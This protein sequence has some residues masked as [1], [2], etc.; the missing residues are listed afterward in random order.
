MELG[1]SSGEKKGAPISG[2]SQDLSHE[3]ATSWSAR[4]APDR[5]QTRKHRSSLGL[6][7]LKDA[8]HVCRS[9]WLASSSYDIL[10]PPALTVNN[11]YYIDIIRMEPQPT[12]PKM[13]TGD[14][15]HG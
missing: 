1:E 13:S 3:I 6:G 8:R 7:S 14:A 10:A 5:I 15:G 9:N 11:Y 4:D 12:G 2:K